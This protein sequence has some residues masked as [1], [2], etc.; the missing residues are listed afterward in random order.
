MTTMTTVPQDA[1]S[2]GG[3]PTTAT[4][5]RGRLGLITLASLG[6][7]AVSALV[8]TL[9]AFPGADEPV[10]TGVGLLGL[11]TGWG[12]LAALSRRTGR[13][14]SWAAVPALVMATAGVA[15]LV[16]TPGDA[17]LSAAGWVWAPVMAGVAVW[18]AVQARRSLDSWARTWLVLPTLGALALVSVGGGYQTVRVALDSAAYPM[19]GVSVDVGEYSLHLDCVG[20]GRPTVV[21]ESGLGGS[22]T[23]WSRIATDVS[24]TTRVCAYDHAG[25]GWSDS[26]ESPRDALAIATDLRS[27]LDAA[28][29]TGPYVLV[30]HSVGGSYA[31][32]FASE[33][34]TA[35]AGMVLLD[36]TSPYDVD[37]SVA[38]HA[39]GAGGPMALLPSIARMGLTRLMPSSTWSTL[40]PPAAD[41]FRAYATTARAM[42][43]AV[44]EVSQYASTFAQAQSLTTLGAHPLVVLT[45]AET[46]STDPAGYAAHERFAALSTNSSLRT[47]DTTHV[48][49]LDDEH[50]ARHSA[51]AITDVVQALRTGTPLPQR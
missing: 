12:L 32:T 18:S 30:G 47:A 20:T 16:L 40:P 49:L 26:T 2:A 35:V 23:L 45:L 43:N 4:R 22:S 31:M 41:E 29:E 1:Q 25:Q 39:G 46:K 34:P 37:A 28:G 8:L 51:R 50:G 42:T 15:L 33:H 17:A 6:A 36:A 38:G 10:I 24:R 7:G 9:V 13:P 11:S 5:P 48:G 27:L 44:D 3:S 21:L 14:Q 19:P